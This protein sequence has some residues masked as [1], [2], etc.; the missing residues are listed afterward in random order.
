MNFHFVCRHKHGYKHNDNYS[1]TQDK[2]NEINE[3]ERTVVSP[4][5]FYDIPKISQCWK[6]KKGSEGV[7]NDADCFLLEW[8]LI[9]WQCIM[10]RVQITSTY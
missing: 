1:I 7:P 3:E 2:M 6:E 5:W 4:Y 8:N 9:L 10:P